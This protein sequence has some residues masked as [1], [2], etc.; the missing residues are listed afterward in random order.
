[1]KFT[2]SWLKEYLN[3]DATVGVIADKLTALGLEVESVDDRSQYEPFI[4]AKVVK[5]SQ[6][7]DAE[8]LKL[9]QVD[10]GEPELL[11]IV[12]G[13][14]NA[15][16]GLVGV[17]ARPGVYVPGLDITLGISKIR[18]VESYGMMCSERE[19][20]LSDE[21]EGI[22]ELPSDAPIGKSF[23]SYAGLDDP[24]I[25]INLTPNRADCTGVYGIARDLAAA[26]LGEFLPYNPNLKI[27]NYEPDIELKLQDEMAEFCPLFSCRVIKGV[28]NGPSP[29]WLADRL[30][31][32]G[33]KSINMV[34]DVT[35]YM[36]VSYGQPLHAFDRKLLAGDLTIGLGVDEAEFVALDNKV[37][38]LA[39]SDMVIYSGGQ[40]VSLAGIMGGLDSGCS[41]STTEIVLESAVWDKAKIAATGRRLAINSDARYRFERGVDIDSVVAVLDLAAQLILQLGGGEVSSLKQIEQP[42]AAAKT[43]IFPVK[44]IKRLLGIE[45]SYEVVKQ[46]LAGLGLKILQ[47][48]DASLLLEI[49][50]WRHDLA[51]KADIVEEVMRL[52]GVDNIAPQSFDVGEI[53]QNC[54]VMPDL[55]RNLAA[56][57][58]LEAINYSFISAKQAELFGGVSEQLTILNPISIEMSHLRPSLLPGLLSAIKRNNDRA[59]ADIALF[60]IGHIYDDKVATSQLEAAAVVRQGLSKA[61]GVTGRYWNTPKAEVDLFDAKQDA[62][63]ILEQYGLTADKVQL[64]RDVPAWYHPGRAGAIKLGSKVTLGYFGEIHP[65]IAKYFGLESSVIACEIFLDN[66]PK[67]RSKATKTKPALELHNLQPLNRDFAFLLEEGQGVGDLLKAIKACDKK[68]IQSVQVFDVFRGKSLPEGKYSVAIEVVLQPKMQSFTDAELEKISENIINA[69]VKAVGATLRV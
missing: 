65:S 15:R 41:D 4:I 29:R 33:L 8:R 6:H 27:S 1:M 18:G 50:S 51:D 59:L 69:A 58:L 22:I 62:L 60:E 45:L 17:L 24:V 2:L 61:S 16:E 57:G 9:L 43:V 46:Y 14:S 34:V 7:P 31:A 25:E 30:R 5:A 44:E 49:P 47:N 38:K 12:C 42:R 54:I 26:G 35:N 21:H 28:K 52:Y 19:L 40:P 63:L 10:I 11:Q 32:I 20:L 36:A 37:Y 53:E 13:A 66:I 56:T 48:D 3:T 55:R 64:S 68:N 23:A 39:S 67:A